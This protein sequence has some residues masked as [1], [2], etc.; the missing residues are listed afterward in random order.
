MRKNEFHY[1]S[2]DGQT[3]I[4]GIEWIPDGDVKGVLQICH[5]MV[6]Y[7]DRYDEFARYM[8]EQGFYVVG[9]DHL[10]HGKSVQSEE[11]YG[12]FPEKNGNKYVIGD[13]HKLR[14]HTEDKYPDV[15]YFMLGHSM[16]SFLLRQYLTMYADGLAGAV[17]MGTGYQPYPVL[18]FG[19]L[20]CK[21]IAG[22]K[23]WKFR[24]EF[25][26]G[27]S[28]GAFNKKFEP[29]E[30]GSSKDWVC[31]APEKLDEYIRDPLCSFVF[32]VGGYYQMFEG[33]KVLT[34]KQAL[35]RM[36]KD[37]PIF[38][39]AGEDDPVGSFGKNVRK[40]YHQ[41][42]TLGMKDVSIH[43]YE[44]DR[45]EILNETDREKVYADISE[46]ILTKMK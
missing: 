8:T 31:S 12:H 40:V 5:G 19:Q 26:N 44:G 39:V 41:Y 14:R 16:G 46:W 23:D 20:I 22:V 15:P 38:F 9:H 18:A 43:L 33:M 28:F 3:T 13:I 7:I 35:E 2:T 17:I 45:H 32:T 34:K 25:V 37:L 36:P 24:S 21:M 27:L 4:H 29:S 42:K 10:G 6:E 30:T 1:S 11:H